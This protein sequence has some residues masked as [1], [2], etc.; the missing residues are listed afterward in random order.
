METTV[1]LNQS[2]ISFNEEK[3]KAQE[4]ASAGFW[5]NAEDS[6]FAISP[7]VLL[8]MCIV[9]GIAA[10]SGIIDSWVQLA[11]VAFPSTICLALILALAP[12]RTI[13]IGASIAVIIDVLV[14][15]F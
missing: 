10:A 13:I 15:I 14:I 12:M 6:R 8:V 3:I 4:K 7:L 1:K 5:K 2:D 9:G 11:A